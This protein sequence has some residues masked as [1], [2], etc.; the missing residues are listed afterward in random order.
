MNNDWTTIN[1]TQ[2]TVL[3][4]SAT[5]IAIQRPATMQLSDWVDCTCSSDKCI[6]ADHISDVELTD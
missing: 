5:V 2:L 3:S 6:S 4:V 1:N